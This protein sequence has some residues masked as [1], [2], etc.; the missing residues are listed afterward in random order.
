M[1]VDS[2]Q[3][4][5]V[6]HRCAVRV[7]FRDDVLL[8]DD[9]DDHGVEEQVQHDRDGDDERRP[10]RRLLAVVVPQ[11]AA[12]QHDGVD[13]PGRPVAAAA[14][15]RAERGDRGAGA[16]RGRGAAGRAQRLLDVRRP[17]RPVRGQPVRP[18]QRHGH[19]RGRQRGNVVVRLAHGR[20]AGHE[21]RLPG[22]GVRVVD[23]IHQPPAA[24]HRERR[25]QHDR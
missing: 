19:G 20:H 13:E 1:T 8:G 15:P 18:E 9:R 21:R 24:G 3:P 17:P 12:A 5:S 4:P 25:A 14:V 22:L 23:Q 10:H 11:D 7:H 16:G 2:A 6:A